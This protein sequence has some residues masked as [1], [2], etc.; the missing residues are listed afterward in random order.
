MKTPMHK[1][2]N[3][4][5]LMALTFVI[6]PSL[7]AQWP[8]HPTPGVPRTPDD[9]PI[10]TG[11]TPRTDDGKPDFTVRVDQRITVDTEMIEFICNENNIDP[12]HKV[13]K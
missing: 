4:V 8:P 6:S 12:K 1:L 3:A 5:G 2:I 11:P 13:G 7:A 10:L 9:K